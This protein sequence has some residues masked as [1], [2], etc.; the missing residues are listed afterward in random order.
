L[1]GRGG[2]EGGG[3][4]KQT[5]NQMKEDNF[6]QMLQSVLYNTLNRHRKRHEMGLTISAADVGVVN[7][8]LPAVFRLFKNVADLPANSGCPRITAVLQCRRT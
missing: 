2:Y 4:G 7:F 1:D 3:S 8:I 6:H 5:T